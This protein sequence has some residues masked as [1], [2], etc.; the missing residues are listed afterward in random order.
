MK[1]RRTKK[2]WRLLLWA[3]IF[4]VVTGCLLYLFQEQLLFHP[5]RLPPDHPYRF[6]QPFREVNF[7]AGAQSLHAV[8]LAPAGK[9]KG[10]VLFFHGNMKHV[11]YYRKY[12]AYF[13]ENGY[14]VWMAEY[15]SFG[16]SR[17]K[18]SESRLYED[19]LLLYGEALK[20]FRAE[21]I[22]IYGKSIG[23]GVAAFLASRK[24][25]KRLILETPYQSIPALA[26]HYF[27]IY[28]VIMNRYKLPSALYIQTVQAPVTIFHGT[29]D[30]VV[31][32]R[33]GKALATAAGAEL[34]TVNGGR[35]NN[36]ATYPVFERKL[37]SLLAH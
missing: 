35:H 8:Q 37:D 20:A 28:P 30:G 32:Y 18:L 6:G 17:G 1:V 4:Y 5:E 33:Q 36:L 19:A 9:P 24:N 15:P 13:T 34:V 27:P 12:P 23:T 21:D 22:V 25:C 16:K 3:A 31:P 10:L 2:W 14:E 7:K 11:E 26:R 29:S